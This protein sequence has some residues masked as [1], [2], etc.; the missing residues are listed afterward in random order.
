MISEAIADADYEWLDVAEEYTLR[1]IEEL[2]KKLKRLRDETTS[3]SE[4]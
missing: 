4:T 1:L 2:K 3:I